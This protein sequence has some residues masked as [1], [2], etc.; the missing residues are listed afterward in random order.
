MNKRKTLTVAGV[1]LAAAVAGLGITA[2][3]LPAVAETSS[4]SS[5]AAPAD[6]GPH[7]ANGIT[8]QELTG[9]TAD[10]VKAAVLAKYPDATIER[11]ETDAE[12][13]AYEAH[14]TE[15]D[16]TRAT[17]KLDEAFAVTAT[18]TG[19]PGGRPGSNGPESSD[20]SGGAS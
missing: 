5:T 8:E 3:A 9:D 2:A 6:R 11:M 18:E 13:A 16:G 19:G 15:A 12:G 10:Q 1:S 20:T 7:S 4:S 17:V 14:I